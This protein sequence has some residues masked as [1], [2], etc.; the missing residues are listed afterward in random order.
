MER[1]DK[2]KLAIKKGITC[3]PETGI[4]Y[5][6]M[7]KELKRTSKGYVTIAMIDE[8][9]R[10]NITAHQFIYYMVTGKTADIIDHINMD[11]M[12]N[13]I[14]NLREVTKSVNTLNNKAKGYYYHKQAKKWGAQ[15]MINGKNKSLGLYNTPEEAS[16]AYI[17]EKQKYIL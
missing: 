5:G 11:R 4:V 8:G 3:N 16:N 15:I 6:V 2:I 7:G 10:I 17:T 1:L 13:R 9:K 14:S 12:D